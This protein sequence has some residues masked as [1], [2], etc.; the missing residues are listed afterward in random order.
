MKEIILTNTKIT[1]L[2]DDDLF[3]FLT[4]RGPW[5]L[6]TDGYVVTSHQRMGGVIRMHHLVLNCPFGYE[7]HHKD[8]NRVNN[9]RGNLENLT[10]KE[11]NKIHGRSTKELCK[12]RL[13]KE[14]QS[15]QT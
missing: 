12:F 6:Y 5:R 4:Q 9:Q 14:Q 15:H 8:E 7:T 13:K 11:H 2:V 3:E 1:A 10:R